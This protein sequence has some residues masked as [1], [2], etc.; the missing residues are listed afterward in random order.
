MSEFDGIILILLF[1]L[2]LVSAVGLMF[3]PSKDKAIIIGLTAVSSLLMFIISF[4][5]FII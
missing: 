2:P 1:C 5:I 3:V 4:Y